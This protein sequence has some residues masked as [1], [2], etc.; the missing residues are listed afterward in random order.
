MN[1]A[2]LALLSD[3][4]LLSHV[5]QILIRERGATAALVAHLSEIENRRLHLARGYAS[6]FN[7]CTRALHLS[8]HAAYNRIEAARA[9]RRFPAVLAALERGDV[10]LTAVRLLS[11][12][13]SDENHID[14]LAAAKHKSRREI[15]ELVARLRPQPDARAG[16]RRLPSARRG[17][18]VE[19]QTSA[20]A[21]TAAMLDMAIPTAAWPSD[22]GEVLLNRAGNSETVTPASQERSAP[23]T[24]GCTRTP[25]RPAA[26]VPLAPE[27]YKAQFTMSAAMRGKL[28]RAQEL[29][30]H[31]VPG[32]D[33]AQVFELALD[34]LVHDLEK[35]KF[36][37]T[38]RPAPAGET[39]TMPASR[40]VPA[41]VKRAVWQRDQGRCTF[42]GPEGVRCTERGQLEFDHIHPHADGGPASTSNVRLLCRAHNQHEAQ[43][44]FGLWQADAAS[45]GVSMRSSGRAEPVPTRPETSWPPAAA[46][47][48]AMRSAATERLFHRSSP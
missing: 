39:A 47:P 25:A 46:D 40:H 26:V 16:V 10:H 33:L 18:A 22:A 2:S 38:A 6:L 43:Q 34:L 14:L 7:Y 31:R 17:A 3:R 11:P 32:G 20:P 23:D 9:A 21:A 41:G 36:A 27:R 44:F 24:D 1:L 15:E 45:N 30:G 29:L 5:E 48:L 13:F 8:E 35:K 19:P 37:A 28:Q 42:T 12:V 4:E